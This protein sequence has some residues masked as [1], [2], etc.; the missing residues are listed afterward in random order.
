MWSLLHILAIPPAGPR[1]I[2]QAR[3]LS[4]DLARAAGRSRP[5]G[6][7]EALAEVAR[8]LTRWRVCW[9]LLRPALSGRDWRRLRTD[10]REQRRWRAAAGRAALTGSQR[11]RLRG[12]LR[13]ER[14]TL[15]SLSAP[16][17]NAALHDRVRR[18]HRKARRSAKRSTAARRSARLVA[19]LELLGRSGGLSKRGRLEKSVLVMSPQEFRRELI[20]RGFV[21]A[22]RANEPRLIS[23]DGVV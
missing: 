15:E 22:A 2:D 11:K 3:Q 18:L 5:A 17:T 10:L 9:Y 14:R 7:A 21:E 19:A 6:D 20:W 4:G 23:P 1:L 12:H 8:C 13:R 16:P